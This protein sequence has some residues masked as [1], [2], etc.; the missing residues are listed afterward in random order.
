MALFLDLYR[1]KISTLTRRKLE[2]LCEIA[3]I[4]NSSVLNRYFR[5]NEEEF[6]AFFNANRRSDACLEK[7]FVHC[8]KLVDIAKEYKELGAW[9]E[10][11]RTDYEKNKTIRA[12]VKKLNKINNSLEIT[13]INLVEALQ[14]LIGF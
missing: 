1:Q 8:K 5:E 4:L 2:T 14:G 3:T 9:L 7:Y 11:G 10:E 6:F 13:L 12:V